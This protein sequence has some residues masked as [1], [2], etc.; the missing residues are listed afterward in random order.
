[1]T[2]LYDRIRTLVPVESDSGETIP[3]GTF[4]T[5]VECYSDPVE[6]YSVDLDLLDSSLV[7]GRRFLSA[8]LH[9]G[10]FEVLPPGQ[11][12]GEALD[13]LYCEIYMDTELPDDAVGRIIASAVGGRL[14]R[15]D[16]EAGATSMSI[17]KN[18]YFDPDSHRAD[19]SDFI[20]FPKLLEIE[21]TP[22]AEQQHVVSDVCL[23]LKA[24][25]AA[26]IPAVAACAYE[27]D[28]PRRGGNPRY[29]DGHPPWSGE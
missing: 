21:A 28:L 11:G 12:A 4:G 17:M 1:M 22:H 20:Y 27:D 25:W 23:V 13:D 7:G 26:H 24:L 29:H 9:P 19:P 8:I 3:A 5:V 18:G 16:I 10:Q 14:D 6:G 2:A 15:G